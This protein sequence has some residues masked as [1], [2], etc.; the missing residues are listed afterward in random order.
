MFNPQNQKIQK[1]VKHVDDYWEG[2]VALHFKIKYHNRVKHVV[3]D[4]WE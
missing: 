2:L 4:D 3:E 1:L